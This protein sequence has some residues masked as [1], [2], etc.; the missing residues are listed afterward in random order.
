MIRRRYPDD[1]YDRFWWPM[2][3]ASPRWVNISTT[4]PIQPDAIYGVP[5]AIL[6]TAVVAGGNDTAITVRTWQY[7]TPSSYSFMILLHFVDFQDTQLR[8]FDIYINEDDPS[9]IEL[10]SYNK[11]SY[12]IPSHVY[13]ESYRAPDGSY[14]ITL[15]KTN[16]SV[17]PPMINALEIYLRVPYEN[18]TTLAQ[19]CKLPQL[20]LFP[21]SKLDVQFSC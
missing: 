16:A 10:K 7:D 15:A 2:D 13:T 14:N 1:R 4:R 3:E 6:K 19:D 18:P 21:S 9:G 8:Q 11:T 17:L 5:S 20:S 12:L